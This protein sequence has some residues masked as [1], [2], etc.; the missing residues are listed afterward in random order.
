MH[1]RYIVDVYRYL[2]LAAGNI[3]GIQAACICIADSD[4]DDVLHHVG[5]CVIALYNTGVRLSN[6]VRGCQSLC[7]GHGGGI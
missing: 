4:A 6:K 2:R 1:V 5:E 7:C 3:A